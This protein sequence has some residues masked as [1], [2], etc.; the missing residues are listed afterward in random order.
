MNTA[1]YFNTICYK[2]ETASK[3]QKEISLYNSMLKKF[4]CVLFLAHWL[5]FANNFARSTG[6]F[7]T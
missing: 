3:R 6:L 2:K 5:L 1:K 7:Q 4:L